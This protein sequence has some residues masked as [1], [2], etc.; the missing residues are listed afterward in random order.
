MMV[1]MSVKEISKKIEEIIDVKKENMNY[2]HQLKDTLEASRNGLWGKCLTLLA[3]SLG[4]VFGNNIQDLL[5]DTL[6]FDTI[7]TVVQYIA[8]IKPE[9]MGESLKKELQRLEEFFRGEFTRLV[10]IIDNL[11]KIL[12]KLN[13]EWSE[14]ADTDGMQKKQRLELNELLNQRLPESG[15]RLKEVKNKLISLE[16]QIYSKNTSE[17]NIKIEV[18]GMI[19]TLE[20]AKAILQMPSTSVIEA[21]S[22]LIIEWELIKKRIKNLTSPFSS[23]YSDMGERFEKIGR[24][25]YDSIKDLTAAIS[26]ISKSLKALQD[27][28]SQMFE[29]WK[30]SVNHVIRGELT[31]YKPAVILKSAIDNYINTGELQQV[32]LYFPYVGIPVSNSTF[33]TWEQKA[34]IVKLNQNSWSNNIQTVINILYQF[35]A[36]A[37]STTLGSYET[38]YAPVTDLVI[39]SYKVLTKP[40]W[41]ELVKKM[42]EIENILKMVI[43]GVEIGT[44]IRYTFEQLRVT[45]VSIKDILQ[46]NIISYFDLNNPSIAIA[47]AMGLDNSSRAIISGLTV[48]A[49]YLGMDN[50]SELIS[51]GDISGVLTLNEGQATVT[52]QL[53]KD[54]EELIGENVLT[55][56]AAI[57]MRKI[58]ASEKLRKDRLQKTVSGLIEEGIKNQEE[59]IKKMERLKEKF[60]LGGN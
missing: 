33:K 57:E 55:Q 15:K 1:A 19:S 54:L 17:S 9:L 12:I 3:E 44:D 31:D 52:Q 41:N 11:E 56:N 50:L 43:Q 25:F 29:Q 36:N 30:Y 37:S 51:V 24:K 53:L 10:S 46:A 4:D 16:N 38:I 13:N 23:N 28:D 5:G 27:Y 26:A 48:L 18:N 20:N 60:Q 35:K 32:Q 34:N 14:L 22:E 47:D 45:C 21:F 7:K 59:E 8:L 39:E 6:D 58:F 40:L 49:D 42:S 2:F